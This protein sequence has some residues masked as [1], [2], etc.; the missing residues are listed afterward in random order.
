MSLHRFNVGQKVTFQPDRGD[1][2]QLRG[3]YTVVRPLPS[4]TRDQQYRVKSDQDGHERV[5]RESQLAEPSAASTP[6]DP[7]SAKPKPS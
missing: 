2:R 4:E 1:L 7:W 3:S 5:V 6:W